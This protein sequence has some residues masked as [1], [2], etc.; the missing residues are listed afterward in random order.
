MGRFVA[1]TLCAGLLLSAAARFGDAASEPGWS[2]NGLETESQS[3]PY[4]VEVLT[5]DAKQIGLT[6]AQLGSKVELRLVSAGLI[7][8]DPRGSTDYYLYVRVL[9]AK[10]AFSCELQFRRGVEFVGARNTR[11]ALTGARTWDRL[12]TGTHGGRA[13]FV[14]GVLDNLLDQFLGEYLSVNPK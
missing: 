8:G 9:I 12:I 10:E 11:Y 3:V 13:E 4:V 1:V 2:R 5:P 7:P 6:E 14:L